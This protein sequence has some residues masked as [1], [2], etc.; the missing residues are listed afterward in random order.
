MSFFSNV[1]TQIENI[2][3]KEE[4]AFALFF[5]DAIH[6]VAVNGGPVL[7]NAATNAVEA[8]EKQGGSGSAKLAAA[9][10]A[11]VATLTTQGIPVV[12]SAVNSAIEA[13]V[14]RLAASTVTPPAVTPTTN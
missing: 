5:E 12:V 7:V 10:A 13:A 4:Q 9:T 8:A 14:A 2:F 3:T 11:V 1:W 6:N